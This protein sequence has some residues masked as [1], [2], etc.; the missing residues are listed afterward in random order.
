MTER[1]ATG[2]VYETLINLGQEVMVVTS[3]YG[4][5]YMSSLSTPDGKPLPEKQ[6]SE[7]LFVH[8]GDRARAR[9]EATTFKLDPPK[10]V[11]INQVQGPS[12]TLGIVSRCLRR[13]GWAT[14]QLPTW[15]DRITFPI[16]T[17]CYSAILGTPN[18]NG[19][20][21]FLIT[22]KFRLKTSTIA[23]VTV[24]GSGSRNGE[25]QEVPSLLWYISKERSV[26]RF[27]NE[28]EA[29]QEN[30]PED[31]D[32]TEVPHR[33]QPQPVD[34]RGDDCWVGGICG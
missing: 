5:K 28:N 29:Y 32:I 30:N 17:Y 6:L 15:E 11:L 13:Y 22:H 25:G 26:R 18:S 9:L 4:P 27:R 1:P 14:Q 8:W 23:S 10:W 34:P 2:A 12:D 24:Y 7:G 19:I 3:A 16:G 33:L 21:M 20:A 31:N